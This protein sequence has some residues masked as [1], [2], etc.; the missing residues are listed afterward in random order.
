MS[1]SPAENVVPHWA[2]DEGRREEDS[3]RS[4]AGVGRQEKGGS[5]F[6]LEEFPHSDIRGILTFRSCVGCM[7]FTIVVLLFSRVWGCVSSASASFQ[8]LSR[9]CVLH[10]GGSYASYSNCIG[11]SRASG[12]YV[13]VCIC[14]ILYL[15]P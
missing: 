15:V 4:R 11:G 1:V 14:L 13:N 10:P 5:F 6:Q 7:L 3:S 9:R 8:S 2:L 12:P